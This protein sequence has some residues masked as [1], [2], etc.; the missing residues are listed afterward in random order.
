MNIT[1][2]QLKKIINEAISDV[3]DEDEKK[4]L[5]DQY[6]QLYYEINGKDTNEDL[7]DTSVDDLLLKIE[8]L[9]QQEEEENMRNDQDARDEYYHSV[10]H[11]GGPLSESIKLIIIES[12]EEAKKY[13]GKSMRKGGGGRFAK[14]VDKLKSS[15]KSEESAKAI[16]ASVGRKKYGTKEMARMAK[17]GKKRASKKK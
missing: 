1:V 4:N 5:I 11:R 2:N 13:K 12:L 10:G 17:A 9:K 6:Q 8:N 14:L 15:G 16:A 7:E 3:E